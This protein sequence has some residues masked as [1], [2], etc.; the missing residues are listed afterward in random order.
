M[1][2]N[3]DPVPSTLGRLEGYRAAL[4]ERGLPY[5]DALVTSGPITN[6]G[7]DCAMRLLRLP[8]RPTA[9]FC[10]NDHMAMAAYDAIRKLGLRIP[11]DVAV[12]GFDDLELIAAY[13]YPGLTTMRLP[14]YDMGAWAVTQMLTM[15][16][17]EEEDSPARRKMPCPLV[18]R[19][20]T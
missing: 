9:L 19:A 10:Y 20:S 14:H 11:D 4:A 16:A 7:Y 1:I 3:E 5:D 6:G 8:D 2:N 17:S 18:A 12:V 13:L 15:L